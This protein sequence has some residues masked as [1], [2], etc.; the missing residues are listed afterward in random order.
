MSVIL[1]SVLTGRSEGAQTTQTRCTLIAPP[2]IYPQKR[3]T[4]ALGQ[5]ESGTAL[6]APPITVTRFGASLTH[7]PKT[8]H[9]EVSGDLDVQ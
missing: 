6:P 9:S 1:K 3:T 8:S 2:S 7:P 4:Q 5:V